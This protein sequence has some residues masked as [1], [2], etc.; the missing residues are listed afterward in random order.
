M[1]DE[2]ED[3]PGGGDDGD[4]D[5]DDARHDDDGLDFPLQEGSFPVRNLLAGELYLSVLF[6]PQDGGE[7]IMRRS[8]RSF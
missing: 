1:V 8:L 6:P 5:L 4:D 7:K 2:Y 3:G